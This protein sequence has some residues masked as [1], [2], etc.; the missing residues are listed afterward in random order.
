MKILITGS[1]GMIG[2]R[3]FELLLDKGY[4]VI[5]VDRKTN[6]WN[7][8]LN[9][10]TM[11]IDILKYKRLD[12]IPKD[13]DMIIHLAANARVYE[14]IKN[15]YLA[16]ENI[17]TTFNIME[18][19][20]K[21]NINKIVFSSSREVYGNITDDHNVSE[22]ERILGCENTYS[23]SKIG[24]E[25]IIHSYKKNYGIDFVI[26]R[27]SNIYG[28]YDD[29]DRVIPLWIKK[30]L[31]NEELIIIGEDKSLDFIHIDDAIHGSVKIIDRLDSIKG[32][33]FNMASGESV[34]LTFVA[35][36]IKEILES[37]SKISTKENRKGET[38]KFRADITKAR[39]LLG[40][41]PEI[42]IE[43]GLEKTVEWYKEFY[44]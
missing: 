22:N 25:A 24:A 13:I 33:V 8:I 7:H 6:R 23:A 40:Y 38:M 39:K 1:S 34:K 43:K 17:I 9:K 15:P 5:G 2:S 35:N 16:I 10:K 27:F 31:K 28:M 32:E 3:L 29:S 21:R 11:N 14:L 44:G 42:N 20:R 26:M 41:K 30:A 12:S 4:D 19:A 37:K 36:K 18:F